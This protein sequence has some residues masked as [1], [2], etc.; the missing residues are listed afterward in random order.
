MFLSDGGRRDTPGFS[1]MMITTAT[2]NYKL[3]IYQLTF[4][5]K[6]DSF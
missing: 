4:A 5:R 6:I 2:I 1:M 3:S